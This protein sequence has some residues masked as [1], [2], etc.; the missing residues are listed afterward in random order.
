MAILGVLVAIL[1][2]N[3]ISFIGEGE[4]QSNAEVHHTVQLAVTAA[5]ARL[6][7]DGVEVFPLIEGNLD[8]NG[9]TARIA[10]AGNPFLDVEPWLIGGYDAL[11]GAV[12]H[13]E[14]MGTTLVITPLF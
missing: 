14:S 7:L 5:C 4:S 12:F 11:K 10:A 2:P 8:S 1:I 9:C 13:I 3:V 6:A